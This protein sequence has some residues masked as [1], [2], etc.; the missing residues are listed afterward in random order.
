MKKLRTAC[1]AAV[2]AS[3]V[4]A[5]SVLAQRD[6][7]A[8]ILLSCAGDVTVIRAGG[9][10]THG[11]FGLPLYAGDEV[12]TADGAEAEIHFE[13]GTWLQVGAN[14]RMMIKGAGTE[15]GGAGVAV[16]EKSFDVVQNML[17]LKDPSGTSSL[18]SLRSAPQTPQIVLHS[19]CNTSIRPGDVMFEWEA[20]DLDEALRLT[21]YGNAGVVYTAPVSGSG[22]LAYPDDASA[23]QPGVTYSWTV[24]TT[25]PLRIPP[26]RSAAAFFEILSADEDAAL[27]GELAAIDPS[28]I[29]N[30]ATWHFLRASAFFGHGLNEDAIDELRGALEEGGGTREMRAI[31][32]R[33]L[34]E[35]GR[36]AEAMEEYGR[37][38]DGR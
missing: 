5:A 4:L 27:D 13:N 23:L 10:R 2:L 6:V 24:E 15:R 29:R 36:T 18:A 11:S 25:D 14:G 8:A 35:T 37:I 20:P 1:A 19:P 32:A 7:P 30:R 17:R 34:A 3:A 38:M 12:R 21:L 22:S 33:L 28:Q 16:G 26:I 31:L 9:E